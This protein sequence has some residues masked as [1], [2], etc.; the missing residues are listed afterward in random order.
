MFFFTHTTANRHPLTPCTLY[1]LPIHPSTHPPSH[2]STHPLI[3]Y[4]FNRY[5]MML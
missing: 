2:S 1:L 4:L 3:P 5:M